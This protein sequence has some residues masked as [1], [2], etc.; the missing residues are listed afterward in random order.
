MKN[1]V[2]KIFKINVNAMSLSGRNGNG[3]QEFLWNGRDN[4]GKIERAG[5]YVVRL[6]VEGNICTRRVTILR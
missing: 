1:G 6:E 5:K 4:S 3:N 2:N